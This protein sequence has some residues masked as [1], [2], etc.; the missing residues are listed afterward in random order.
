MLANYGLRRILLRYRNA[1]NNTFA[2]LIPFVLSAGIL[3]GLSGAHAITPS[4]FKLGMATPNYLLAIVALACPFVMSFHKDSRSE[5]LLWGMWMPSLF[6]WLGLIISSDNFMMH[7]AYPL[8]LGGF[9]CLG[10]TLNWIEARRSEYVSPSVGLIESF[11][12]AY[13]C[14]FVMLGISF[15]FAD[16]P[17]WHFR[18]CVRNGPHKGIFTTPET[19]KKYANINK[20]LEEGVRKPGPILFHNSF[21]VGYLM[22]NQIPGARNLYLVENEDRLMGYYKRNPSHIPHTVV[23]LKKELGG[24]NT[25]GVGEQFEDFLKSRYRYETN[26]DATLIKVFT[27]WD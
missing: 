15:P 2:P 24:F 10:I 12:I 26:Q 8:A 14:L 25:G 5:I 27:R 9:A 20:A 19:A 21:P 4:M 7:A 13:C 23:V 16:K 3:A 17:V 11:L 6:A 22:V 18:Q 1:R